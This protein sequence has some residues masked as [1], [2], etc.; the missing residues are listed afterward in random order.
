[1]SQDW[2]L[3]VGESLKVVLMISVVGMT[4]LFLALAFFYS[5]LSLLTAAIRDRSPGAE[6][7]AAEP[8][9]DETLLQAAALA[10]ALARAES[11]L[12]TGPTGASVRDEAA[13]PLAVSPWW[14]LHHQRQ[15]ASH[16]N[17]RRPR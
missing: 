11:E 2:R 13:T 8:A 9:E 1:M 12:T 17:T 6:H 15:L 16:A 3:E 14:A 7:A 4:L 10:V 5:L